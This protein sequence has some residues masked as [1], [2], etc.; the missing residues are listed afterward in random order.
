MNPIVMITGAGGGLGSSTAELV[1]ASGWQVARVTRRADAVDAPGWKPEEAI[2]ADVSTPQGADA[3]V[4]EIGQRFGQAPSGLINCA[5]SIFISPLH[6]TKE[7]QYRECLQANLDS[8][9]F[10]LAAFVKALIKEKRPGAAVLV[11]TVAARIGVANHEAVAAAKGAVE[12]LVRSAAA[13]Y[14]SKGIRVNAIAPGLMK[15]PSTNKFFIND[16]VDQQIAAQYPLGRY[17]RLEDA[18]TAAVWLLSD[19][20]QWITGQILPVDGGFS[21]VRPMI[22]N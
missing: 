12:G 17:G 21:V 9:F 5:G 15:A 19:A 8:A 2:Q 3:A 11:S 20:A 1:R 14:S 4:A 18:A 6:R 7:K 22:R 10:A 13:T 16:K